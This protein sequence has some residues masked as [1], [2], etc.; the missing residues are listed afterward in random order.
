[1]ESFVAAVY[2]KAD[3][4]NSGKITRKALF[5]ALDDEDDEAMELFELD[6][7]LKN[8]KQRGNLLKKYII[9]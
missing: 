7:S 3:S 6:P 5:E 8:I 4:T 1:M 2:L 9:D